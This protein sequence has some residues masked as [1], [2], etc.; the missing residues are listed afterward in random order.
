MALA[1]HFNRIEFTQIGGRHGTG[2][3]AGAKLL[4]VDRDHPVA[5]EAVAAVR[6]KAVIGK[7]P[8]HGEDT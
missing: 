5:G 7:K 3:G 2:G 6:R 8:T 1:K 4:P